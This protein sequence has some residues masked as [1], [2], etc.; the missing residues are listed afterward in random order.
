MQLCSAYA[1]VGGALLQPDAEETSD[2]WLEL[3]GG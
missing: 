1:W 2:R 3:P